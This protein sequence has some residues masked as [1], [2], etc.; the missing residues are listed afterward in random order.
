MQ[1]AQEPTL[2]Q[3]VVLWAVP[4]QMYTYCTVP[5]LSSHV[6][7]F[8]RQMLIQRQNAYAYLQDAFDC[9]FRLKAACNDREPISLQVCKL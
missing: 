7:F 8:S 4:S 2:Q 3:R 9:L 6:P 1:A 5:P